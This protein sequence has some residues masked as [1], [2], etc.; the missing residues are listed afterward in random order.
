[1]KR[2]VTCKKCGDSCQADGDFPKFFAWCDVCNDYAAYD[3]DNYAADWM[4]NE[5][6]SAELRMELEHDQ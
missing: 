2:L 5:I 3:M 1:M 4:A 6:D